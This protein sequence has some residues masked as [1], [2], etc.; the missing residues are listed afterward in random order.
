VAANRDS[1]AVP[2]VVQDGIQAS[3]AST[4][5]WEYSIKEVRQEL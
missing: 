5:T 3:T 2:R 1:A 4:F